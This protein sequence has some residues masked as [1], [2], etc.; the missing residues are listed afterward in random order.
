MKVGDEM[1]EEGD[2]GS[3]VPQGTV[4][5]PTLFTVFIDDVDDC[6]VANTKLIKFAVDTKSWK[7]IE[8]DK[9]REE[10]QQ[11]LNN[12]CEWVDRW[13]MSFNAAKCKVMHIGKNN[14]RNTY[15]MDGVT[16][17]T[18]EEEKDVG[19]YVNP[20][21]KP[22]THCKK[23]AN[24]AMAVLKQITN[25]FHYRDRNVFLKLYK[26]YVRPH[27]EFASPAWSPWQKGDIE[28]I[29]R[30]QE[31]ALRMTSGLKGGNYE[32]KCKEAGLETL[33]EKRK[34]QDMAQVFKIVKG[35]DKLDPEKIFPARRQYQNTRQLANP[36]NLTSKQAKTDMRKHNFGIRVVEEWN[37][38][39]D[40]V[41]NTEKFSTFKSQMKRKHM[42]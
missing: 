33:E 32:E 13:G 15:H 20:S 6:T 12:L 2:V 38:L 40:E 25:C 7:I 19:I 1:S 14:P 37:K 27:L 10:L 18:T 9:D 8:S 31:K 23:A 28:T 34:T 17:G 42:Q 24:K 4:L 41:K 30:V 36:W 29:E 22:G 26:Q 5:G 35:I 39:S 21:L 3:G 11:T 16:F